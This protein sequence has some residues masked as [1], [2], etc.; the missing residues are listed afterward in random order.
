MLLHGLP[1][2][3]SR[4]LHRATRSGT[5]IHRFQRMQVPHL[6]GAGGSIPTLYRR[7]I[8]GQLSISYGSCS[9]SFRRTYGHRPDGGM[10][11]SFH[12]GRLGPAEI[13]TSVPS[14][15]II[16]D[17]DII[18][19]RGSTNVPD[20][21]IADVH[22][23]DTFPGTKDPIAGG[24]PVSAVSNADVYPWTDRRPTVIASVFSP[25]HPCRGP[26][27]SRH[28]HPSIRVIIK[29]VAIV[30]GGPA[31]AVIRDPCPSVLRIYPVAAR[32]VRSEPCARAR[33]PYIA[34]IGIADPGAIWAQL[35]VEYL[36]TYADLGTRLLRQG[37]QEGSE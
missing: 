26:F 14:V 3:N 5:V 28:P 12:I 13:S 22:A 24:R 36:E 7:A 15:D 31:P 30:E 20:I 33:H 1:R 32:A 18:D 19:D 27:V 11:K 34:I 21:V 23:G 17:G 25:G 4:V 35:I 6:R 29:P 9:R 16:D 2:L 37:W 8:Y 10:G